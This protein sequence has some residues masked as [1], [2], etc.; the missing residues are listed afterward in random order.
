MSET[1][2]RMACPLCGG[3]Q[4]T[5][6]RRFDHRRIVACRTCA[7]VFASEYEVVELDRWYRRKYPDSADDPKIG[8]WLRENAPVY[9][10]LARQLLGL[11]ESPA[12]VLDVGAGS[13]GFLLA[14]REA[15]PS[16]E[17]HAVESCPAAREHLRRVLPGLQ[18][19]AN[20]A[21]AL[22]GGVVQ[23]DC[24]VLLQ[25]LE[26]VADPLLV[27]RHAAGVLAPGGHLLITVPNRFSYEVLVGP[28]PRS[29]CYGNPTHL[30][31]FDACTLRKILGR[32]GFAQQRRLTA[33]EN[34]GDGAIRSAI[35][36]GMRWAGFST[37]LRVL[38]SR[39]AKS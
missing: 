16:L 8:Q 3:A 30:Q 12:R 32:A 19:P 29:Q 38:A 6:R 20:E 11:L 23:Y 1:V 34:F 5:P 28:A 17:L 4:W 13:G 15:D 21:E 35:R 26:H 18:M 7:L 14:L 37:E 2:R 22:A 24:V 25:C 33:F 9:R 10:S 31:F 36:T 39:A 27:C